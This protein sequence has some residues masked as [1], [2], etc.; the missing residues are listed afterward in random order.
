MSDTQ[1]QFPLEVYVTGSI[2]FAKQTKV[3]SVQNFS[4]MTKPMPFVR[5]NLSTGAKLDISTERGGSLL[6]LADAVAKAAKQ[7]GDLTLNVFQAISDW[8]VD[9]DLESNKVGVM[10]CGNKIHQL[11]PNDQNIGKPGQHSG[12]ERTVIHMEKFKAFH[13]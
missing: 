12:R 6:D 5:I 8:I 13:F 11:L 7:N 10:L 3:K 2:M 9:A 1:N 4:K